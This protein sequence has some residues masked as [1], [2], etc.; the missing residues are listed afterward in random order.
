[1]VPPREGTE[2][3][4]ADEFFALLRDPARDVPL[5]DRPGG[6]V[7]GLAKQEKAVSS[8]VCEIAGEGLELAEA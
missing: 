3:K 1:V 7:L 2:L 8:C 4:R 5:S 6:N